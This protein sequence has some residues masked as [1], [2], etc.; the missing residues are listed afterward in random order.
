MPRFKLTRN[1]DM[2]TAINEELFLFLSA[3]PEASLLPTLRRVAGDRFQED[4]RE[5]SFAIQETAVKTQLAEL[6]HLAKSGRV[7]SLS[8]TRRD[9]TLPTGKDF[10][11]LAKNKV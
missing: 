9:I 6:A 1:G 3:C 7:P 4:F 8:E 2:V 10:S 5:M 11:H